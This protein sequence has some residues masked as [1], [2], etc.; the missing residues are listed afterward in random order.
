MGLSALATGVDPKT[1]LNWNEIQEIRQW[2]ATLLRL[3]EEQH[4]K[5]IASHVNVAGLLAAMQEADGSDLALPGSATA[6]SFSLA[7]MHALM[8]ILSN[9]PLHTHATEKR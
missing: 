1:P 2:V 7:H 4:F 5:K 9:G 8:H 6:P 3:H